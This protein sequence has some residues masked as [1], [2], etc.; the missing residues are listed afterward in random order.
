M[1]CLILPRLPMMPVYAP[2][3]GRRAAELHLL[4][5][6]IGRGLSQKKFG[7][8]RKTSAAEYG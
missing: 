2:S 8:V 5:A 3:L 1:S 4:L 7:S 6:S